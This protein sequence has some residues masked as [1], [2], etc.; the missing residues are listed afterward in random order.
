MFLLIASCLAVGIFVGTSLVVP[1]GTAFCLLLVASLLLYAFNVTR[2]GGVACTAFCL[3]FML[4][5]LLRVQLPDVHILPARLQAWSDSLLLSSLSAI[6]HLGLKPQT[7][8]LLSAMLLGDRSTLPAELVDL[9]RQTGAAHILALSGLHLGILF[10]LFNAVL[11]RVLQFRLRYIIGLAE[12]LLMWG[13]ALLVGFPLSL[14]RASLMMSFL[15]IAQIRMVGNSGEH[16]LGLAAFTLLMFSPMSLFDV[17]FQLSFMAVAGM[18]FFYVPLSQIWQPKRRLVSWT[19]RLFLLS[20]S[21]QIFTLPLQLFYFHSFSFT[22]FVLSP[23]YILLATAILY[24]ALLLLLFYPLGL[25]AG[26]S[27]CL[28]ALVA[29]L[30]RLLAL[31]SYIPFNRVEDVHISA[32]CVLLFYAALLCLIP[33][34]RALQPPYAQP[35]VVRWVMFFRSWPYLLAA[36][37]LMLTIFLCA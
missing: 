21:A 12:L 18:I 16:T 4:V 10:A 19:L 9:Y 36:L 28:E 5:G 25:S 32:P 24:A 31:A 29:A 30:H 26:F 20:F 37:L 34:L 2:K 23:L 27:P 6:Q 7:T 13:Y 22:S 15:V 8:S 35:P 3:F 14:C 11:I 33:S 1:V 17:G